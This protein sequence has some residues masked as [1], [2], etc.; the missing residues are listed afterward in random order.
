MAV[1]AEKSQK[2]MFF[3]LWAKNTPTWAKGDKWFGP[4]ESQL[5]MGVW[6]PLLLQESEDPVSAPGFGI[7]NT[8]RFWLLP[9][10]CCANPS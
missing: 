2:N 1:F 7:D 9:E 4:L 10:S 8:S 5:A 3:Q 6:I